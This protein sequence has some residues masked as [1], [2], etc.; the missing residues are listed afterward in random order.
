MKNWTEVDIVRTVACGAKSR[1]ERVTRNAD[2][3]IEAFAGILFE[4]GTKAARVRN[5]KTIFT[6]VNAARSGGESDVDAVVD[7]NARVGRAG[8]NGLQGRARE[9]ERFPA[10]QIFFA[11]LNPVHSSSGDNLDSL[12]EHGNG[13]RGN[14]KGK[15][16]AVG[17]VTN[18][19]FRVLNGEGH[20][21]DLSWIESS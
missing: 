3:E 10:A 19:G 15:A 14:R 4:T 20:G 1:A 2:E 16:A 8:A 5:G 13:V 6:E 21:M 7:K 9:I 17:Y 18:D 11:Q 12:Q